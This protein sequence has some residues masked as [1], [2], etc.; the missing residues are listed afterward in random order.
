MHNLQNELTDEIQ[1]V[2]QKAVYPKHKMTDIL[3][4]SDLDILIA[5][6]E[7]PV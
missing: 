6:L 7:G 2:S 4:N 5:H 1:F 3:Y